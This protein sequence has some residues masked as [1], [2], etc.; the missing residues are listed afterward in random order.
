M[1]RP[2]DQFEYPASP[3]DTSPLITVQYGAAWIP[4][5]IGVV[6]RLKQFELFLSPPD[7]YIAQIDELIDR[8]QTDVPMIGQT[9]IG[10]VAHFANN[11]NAVPDKWLFCDG[12]AISRDT[13]ALLF[14][15]I[16]EQYG[17]GDGSTTFN[18]PDIRQ[19]F[20]YSGFTHNNSELGF[21]AGEVEHVLNINELPAHR[22]SLPFA[23][24]TGTATNISRGGTTLG[25][26]GLTGSIGSGASHNNMPPFIVLAA[27]IY[28]GV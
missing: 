19:R 25:T 4:V 26:S 24:A 14:A 20:N 23:T 18:L 5:L 16:G 15:A 8:L 13:Y 10:M 2:D 17:A 28:A 7:D 6:E 21:K 11:N 12:S 22:H 27:F 3:P 9:P 1:N